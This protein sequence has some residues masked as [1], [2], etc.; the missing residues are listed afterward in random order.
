MLWRE[1]NIS[2]LFYL[3][4]GHIGFRVPQWKLSSVFANLQPFCLY[5]SENRRQHLLHSRRCSEHVGQSDRLHT[6]PTIRAR[7]SG[8]SKPCIYYSSLT[9]LVHIR[10]RLHPKVPE[11]NDW[12]QLLSPFS[13]FSIETKY[14]VSYVH[15]HEFICFVVAVKNNFP[16]RIIQCLQLKS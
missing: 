11:N 12:C 1:V 6:F 14:S 10:L 9:I 15:I 13:S 2:T 16:H 3:C 7:M 4:S 5:L 8:G